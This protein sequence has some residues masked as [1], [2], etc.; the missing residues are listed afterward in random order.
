MP[1]GVKNLIQP[2]KDGD[3]GTEIHSTTEEH[4]VTV[5]Y[6]PSR[7]IR[8]S[9]MII[10]I[11][12]E[13]ENAFSIHPTTANAVRMGNAFYFQSVVH[14]F[15]KA[16]CD[17]NESSEDHDSDYVIASDTDDD[18][19]EEDVDV[20]SRG[21][22]S[23]SPFPD[24]S[25]YSDDPSEQS[26][27]SSGGSHQSPLI[28]QDR[29]ASP[30]ST[31]LLPVYRN[32]TVSD[33]AAE[34]IAVDTIAKSKRSLGNLVVLGNLM[35]SSVE[36][37]WALITITC[38]NVLE[39]LNSTNWDL[40]T[41]IPTGIAPRARAR[42]VVAYIPS[43]GKL[44]GL[45]SL[46]ST[47]TRLPTS[48]SFEEVY[49][50]QFEGPIANGDCGSQ[51]VDELTGELYGHIVAGCLSTGVAYIMAAHHVFEDMAEHG[52]APVLLPWQYQ[53]L[54]TSNMRSSRHSPLK[55]KIEQNQ[56]S[57]TSV[58]P[59]I[60]RRPTKS[61]TIILDL[62]KR[63][64]SSS[65]PS[66]VPYKIEPPQKPIDVEKSHGRGQ[67]DYKFH[68]SEFPTR[69]H[70][71]CQGCNISYTDNSITTDK[72]CPRCGNIC[73]LVGAPQSKASIMLETWVNEE[74]SKHGDQKPSGNYHD[75][76]E[77][78]YYDRPDGFKSDSSL[79]HAS[80][81]TS[82][83]A[84]QELSNKFPTKYS[85]TGISNPM[86]TLD[87]NS[88]WL[89][90]SWRLEKRGYLGYSN[91]TLTVHT[92]STFVPDKSS[93]PP[94]AIE[95]PSLL[96]MDGNPGN[97]GIPLRNNDKSRS[98]IH[99]LLNN[100]DPHEEVQKRSELSSSR[101]VKC[102]ICGRDFKKNGLL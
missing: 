54:K 11:H 13:N 5:L 17:N 7:P 98:K 81:C 51:V 71:T 70:Y 63:E 87:S 20:T 49:R 44:T 31:Q 33:H 28:N 78:Q 61:P 84:G 3:S 65:T 41:V 40:E 85:S 6:D 100:D 25:V 62:E 15:S 74:S 53:A 42:K 43:T 1:P 10:Y 68:L 48:F 29:P 9:G 14:S 56:S 99:D 34:V 22:A 77:G 92:G 55:I 26:F 8:R 16:S 88:K 102:D 57:N 91:P 72:T 75:Y 82:D 27:W 21:S 94:K 37:D 45:L 2:A 80:S 60:K 47:Y 32:F 4:S 79:L 64:G 39:Y 69:Q 50:V 24:E 58:Q 67:G 36:K 89:D 59:E 12:H 35:V 97:P 83:M 23:P 38:E 30:D 90:Q 96:P 101:Q 52:N 86:G 93:Y 66:K 73:T 19:D 46:S 95:M 76:K 18:Y